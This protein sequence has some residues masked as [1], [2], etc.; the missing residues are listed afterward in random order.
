MKTSEEKMIQRGRKTRPAIFLKKVRIVQYDDSL[1]TI[2]EKIWYD[3]TQGDIPCG[4]KGKKS[5]CNSVQES[6]RMWTVVD[7][8][9]QLWTG[10][11]RYG[12]VWVMV[13]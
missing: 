2:Y 6:G 1:Y 5:S 10:V 9:G 4:R 3:G 11:D 7:G 8:H 12:P 13:G